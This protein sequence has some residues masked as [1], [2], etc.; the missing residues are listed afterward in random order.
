P[1]FELLDWIGAQFCN[2]N[3][4][5]G[6]VDTELTSLVFKAEHCETLP[7]VNCYEISGFFIP[8]D[9]KCVLHE[10]QSYL[11]FKEL[12]FIVV[13]AN[14]F[15]DSLVSWKGKNNEHGKRLSGEHL[16][17]VLMKKDKKCHIWSI[18]DEFDFGIEKY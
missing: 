3:C 12:P 18:A 17:G 16:V 1:D 11:H 13:I 7:V 6:E 5:E 2:I 15:E 4:S 8:K 9:V 10:L 14:G